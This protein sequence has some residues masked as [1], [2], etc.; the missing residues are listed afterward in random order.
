MI[1]PKDDLITL[2]EA[3]AICCFRTVGPIK[4]AIRRSEIVASRLNHRH[5]LVTRES[6]YKWINSRSHRSLL[7]KDLRNLEE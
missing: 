6:L 7:G 4:N 5:Y 3:A 2:K 1:S